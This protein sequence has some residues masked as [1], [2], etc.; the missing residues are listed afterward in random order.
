LCHLKLFYI[1][2]KL[3]GIFI[4][5]AK[6]F[7]NPDVDIKEANKDNIGRVYVPIRYSVTSVTIHKHSKEEEEEEEYI[8]Y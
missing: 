3:I 7:R 1:F 8:E 6:Q 4:I 2:G 5:Q